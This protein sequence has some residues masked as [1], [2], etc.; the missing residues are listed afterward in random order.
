MNVTLFE[1]GVF[2][3]VIKL[4]VSRGDNTGCRMVLMREERER[5]D[6]H[7]ETRKKAMK[8]ESRDWSY[9]AMN[10]VM[11]G[12]TRTWKRQRRILP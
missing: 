10:Q 6:I 3:D 4:R 7:P 2:A 5:I 12:A 11:P 9:T 1:N 8:K